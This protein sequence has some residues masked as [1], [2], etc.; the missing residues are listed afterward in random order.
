MKNFLL[1]LIFMFINLSLGWAQEGHL[2]LRHFSVPLPKQD[3]VF[4]DMAIDDQGRLLLAHRR[5]LLQFDGRS[6]EKIPIG[7]SPLKFLPIDNN[8][9]LLTREGI[10]KVQQDMDFQNKIESIYTPPQYL[11]GQDMVKHHDNFYYLAGGK[12]LV[13]SSSSFQ[14]D[15][16]FESKL[17][18]NDIFTYQDKLYAFEGNFLL[19]YFNNNWLDLNL[20]APEETDFVFS[21]QT[22]SLVFFAYDNG[23]FFAFNGKEFNVFSN[24][25]NEYLK[26]N[27]PV[28][29]KILGNKIVIATLNGGAV[30]VDIESKKIL[31]TI[32]YFNGL[33]SDEVN[34]V[35]MDDQNG[36]WLAHNAGISRTSLD[37][38]IKEFQHYPGLK[39]IPESVLI[40]KDTL[41]VGTNEGLFYLAQIKDYETFQKV[42]KERI[43]IEII[44][45][46]DNEGEEESET[47]LGGLFDG[48]KSMDEDEAYI[49]E[50]LNNYKKIFR[51]EGYR[52]KKLK[53]RLAEKEAFLRD[54]L[55]KIN[56][57]RDEGNSTKTV[58]EPSKDKSKFKYE[59]VNKI[60][61]VSK[62]KSFQFQY[63]PIKRVNRK[64]TDLINTPN[65]IIAI[66]TSGVFL[67]KDT[68]SMKLSDHRFIEKAY[69][70]SGNNNLW[71]TGDFGLY[72]ID[73]STKPTNSQFH[74][75]RSVHDI[76]I[77]ND[78]MALS[79]ENEIFTFRVLNNT[80]SEQKT[81]PIKNDFSDR[82]SVYFDESQ[83]NILKLDG[84]YKLDQ[85]LDS[86]VLVE[87]YEEN[88]KYFLKDTQQSLWLTNQK[89][90]WHILNKEESASDLQWMKILPY[91]KYIHPVPDSSIYFVVENRLLELKTGRG[92]W[93]EPP[94]SFINAV[95]EQDNKISDLENLELL[96]DNNSLRVSVSTIDYLFPEGIS[97]QYYVKGLMDDWSPWSKAGDIDFPYLPSGEYTLQIRSKSG[98]SEEISTFDFSFEVLP[99]YWRTWW[100][101]SLEIGFFSTLILI[102]LKMN[103]SSRNTYLTDTITFLTLILILEFIATILENNLE[104][105]V[106]DSPVYSFVINVALALLI[107]PLG[108][109]MNKIL[110]VM[111]TKDIKRITHEMRTK[112][113]EN[114]KNE[115]DKN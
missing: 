60:V 64:V 53:D 13:L 30:I 3:Y 43:R 107:T 95:Y 40:H 87:G 28:S 51:K 10:S 66:T 18:F 77:Q 8:L 4:N 79:G 112:Q 23:D 16:V 110:L 100:F 93:R 78:Q 39:G 94:T 33:P 2:S 37:I 91:V 11:L 26:E 73:L 27:Y 97:Y 38:P 75:S 101:Y 7:S 12:I 50:S 46:E 15:T 69:Y 41:F 67:I 58:S 61:N 83:L 17:G 82:M 108:K 104:G 99:P 35:T 32:Q 102:S 57:K 88:L 49:E 54:S 84:L 98:F 56:V 96:Y 105:Y 90:Q 81:Y 68:T 109:G 71:I 55:S 19:E 63:I 62:L 76:A 86:I 115:Q 42:M 45:E 20:Y 5:G 14:P 31:H 44:D 85:K 70:E 113:L 6:W 65:G 21:C 72:S 106:E 111:N 92:E 1:P 22:D 24:E 9:Y 114:L 48:S 74:F 34:A 36:I 59:T 89:D 80:L 103:R 29:G 25:L 52:F 47:F